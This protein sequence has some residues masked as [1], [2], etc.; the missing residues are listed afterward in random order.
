[1]EQPPIDLLAPFVQPL[2]GDVKSRDGKQTHCG[3]GTGKVRTTQMHGPV[4]ERSLLTITLHIGVVVFITGHALFGKGTEKLPPV[5]V[6][7][8]VRM[9]NEKVPVDSILA[10]M[11]ESG[12]VYRLSAS[13]LAHLHDEGVADAVVDYMQQTYLEAV[14]RDQALEDW[15]HWTFAVEGYWYGGRPYG[16]PRE[17][18]HGWP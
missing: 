15:V 2:E 1:M 6:E 7:E 8:I 4:H 3:M 13:Q 12:T 17:W 10:K 16:W 18:Y 5:T 9:N 11:R 14:R